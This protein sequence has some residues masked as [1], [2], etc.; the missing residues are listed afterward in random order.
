SVPAVGI[1][2]LRDRLGAHGDYQT[3]PR[4]PHLLLQGRHWPRV[5]A[6]IKRWAG[7][8]ATPR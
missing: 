4:G 3:F 6:T 7:A 5:T 1:Q 2:R 8:R